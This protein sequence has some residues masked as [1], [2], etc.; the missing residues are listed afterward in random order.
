MNTQLHLH[1]EGPP[2]PAEL[3]D[4]SNVDKKDLE[5]YVLKKRGLNQLYNRCYKVTFEASITHMKELLG[6]PTYQQEDSLIDNQLYSI[7]ED[8]WFYTSKSN[9]NE[10]LL[11]DVLVA[12]PGLET[13]SHVIVGTKYTNLNDHDL[14][15]P[16]RFFISI[17]TGFKSNKSKAEA[18][19][20]WTHYLMKHVPRLKLTSTYQEE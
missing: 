3:I 9:Y 18:F 16:H 8:F 13:L 5:E 11:G 19:N 17:A 15:F 20:T 2:G 14:T 1:L 7:Y 4:S 6:E 12:A 10:F